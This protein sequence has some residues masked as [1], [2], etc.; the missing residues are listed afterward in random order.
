MWDL[1]LQNLKET[2]KW[3]TPPSRHNQHPHCQSLSW[4]LKHEA[5]DRNGSILLHFSLPIPYGCSFIAGIPPTIYHW[6]SFMYLVERNKKQW[7][8]GCTSSLF[9]E[10]TVWQDKA[11]A[12]WKIVW[13]FPL[14]EC[15]QMLL[16][17]Q[18]NSAMHPLNNR[19]QV[20]NSLPC[21]LRFRCILS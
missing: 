7:D 6:H 9:K 16:S 21:N 13:C 3:L 4:F 14:D 2:I 5:N 8:I 11:P 19:G 10:T 17:Y 18:V 1:C 15:Y 20:S 12:V